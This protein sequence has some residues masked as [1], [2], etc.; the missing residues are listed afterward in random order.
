MNVFVFDIETVPDVVGGR[1]VHSLPDSLPDKSVADA[2]FAIRRNK[3]GH[4]FL[5]LHLHRIVAI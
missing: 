1:R 2:M 5:P 4:D 3:V